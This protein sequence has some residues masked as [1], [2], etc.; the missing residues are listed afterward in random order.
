MNTKTYRIESV[1]V[2]P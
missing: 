1:K 2:T